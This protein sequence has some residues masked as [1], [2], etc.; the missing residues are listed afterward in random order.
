MIPDK[1]LSQGS[2]M[3]KFFR[4]H[5]VIAVKELLDVDLAPIQRMV[6]RDMW[7]R[8]N[9]IFVGG[10]GSGKTYL[11]A[12]GAVLRALLFPGYRIGL[13]SATF[14]Q[15]L[16]TNL[17]N[18][19]VFTNEGL[20]SSPTEFY[21]SI[22]ENTEIQSLESTNK[23]LDKWINDEKE[24][25]IIK[26]ERGFEIG[27]LYEHKV[28]VLDENMNLIYK[29]LGDLHT[30][31]YL[32]I[33]KGFGLFG[34]D[35]DL[36]SIKIDE[37]WL[38]ND[39]AR[40]ITCPTK[41]TPDL[42]YLF[43]IICGDGCIANKLTEVAFGND[44]P[45]LLDSFDIIIQKFF[46]ITTRRYKG[47]ISRAM[48]VEL[49]DFLIKCGI[50]NTTAIDKS[51]PL[52]VKRSSRE[53]VSSFLSG[54][55]DT[56]GSFG[57]SKVKSGY[58]VGR[59]DLFSVS[60]KMLKEVQAMLLNLDIMSSLYKSR[61][62]SEGYFGNRSKL[63]KF[64]DSY[65]LSIN[66]LANI[67]KFK[68]II[69]FRLTRKE[70]ELEQYLSNSKSKVICHNVL[71]FSLEI[72]CRLAASCKKLFPG[73]Y[74]SKNNS[75]ILREYRLSKCK[76]SQIGYTQDKISRLLELAK[77]ADVLTYEYHVLKRIINLN[78]EFV[79]VKK[80][81]PHKGK[82]VDV[83][84]ENE[85]CYWAGGFIN[86]N[87]KHIF[88]A[89][90][91]LYQQ[92]PIFQEAVAKPPTKASDSV[93]IRF[94]APPG[95]HGS[96]IEGI[97]LGTGEKIRGARYFCVEGSSLIYTDKGLISIRDI[98]DKGLD[99]KVYTLDGFEAP[100]LGVHLPES[101]VIR[102]EAEG[103][104]TLIGTPIHP[105][106]NNYFDFI[107]LKDLNVGDKVLAFS[108]GIVPNVGKSAYF[109]D[110]RIKDISYTRSD[111]YDFTIPYAHHFISNGF[112]SHNTLCVDE[113]NHIPEDI[114]DAVITPM[115][116]TSMNP[117][118]RVRYY[119]RLDRLKAGGFD[120]DDKYMPASNKLLHT[121]SGYFKFNYLWDRMKFYWS[122]LREGSNDH[123]VWQV[124]YNFLPPHFLDVKALEQA[125]KQM[126]KA[127]FDMEYRALMV[128]DSDGFYKGSLLAAATPFGAFRIELSGNHAEEYILC[129][130]PAAGT[131]VAAFAIMVIK[132]G[133]PN[134]I[135]FAKEMKKTSFPR[136]TKVM[137]ELIFSR[138]NII[139]IFMD[140]GGGG[141]SIRDLFEMG[142][143][144][145]PPVLEDVK[146]NI[147]KSG[148]KI[149]Q[150]VNFSPDWIANANYTAVSLLEHKQLIFPSA[151]LG[152]QK[153]DEED[154][155][156]ELIEKDLKYQILNIVVTETRMGRMHF[157][158]PSKGQK[159]DL[160]STFLL[161]CAGIEQLRRERAVPEL[162]TKLATG[163]VES[164]VDVEGSYYGSGS[165][166]LVG[167]PVPK[168]II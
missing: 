151:P 35:N 111:T 82:T 115:A 13:V 77:Q 8:N 86:H 120:I 26:T 49:C 37:K 141:H 103:G 34:N 74:S 54:L 96:W 60:L 98:I 85:H 168:R 55:Y 50:S 166:I 78:L 28:L 31:E 81:L 110:V 30:G 106:M 122:E 142:V 56:D 146:E 107:Q 11:Q 159:K 114:Y 133:D 84:V 157:D 45:E 144:G 153:N 91:R 125:K 118:E 162:G 18:I 112:V 12:L 40:H 80:I 164:N 7:F 128:S 27:G 163:I 47:P 123:A 129:A 51:I 99:I 134:K 149:L 41:L 130:D 156:Y 57:A 38:K 92:S 104:Y 36:S 158:T 72:T 95:G 116:I 127:L 24:G 165:N 32:A 59:I 87:S 108:L 61:S 113:F 62:A 152:A 63:S 119:E 148:R 21:D 9:V 70:D 100:T 33:K 97:P 137:Q 160:Y 6:F 145:F 79:K 93:Y 154:K 94:K 132:L 150:L 131:D 15:C 25:L 22:T 5:P 44:D 88:D 121:S 2:S 73:F 1:F 124:P 109:Q 65:V 136:M 102:I 43:G 10:R 117:M 19:C 67:K 105:V 29:E 58:N 135:V 20:K 76:P 46:N 138:F 68:E 14:R 17:D 139:R 126:S 48:S 101:D 53:C 89:C 69:G 75:Y 71:P 90:E 140:S 155:V 23:V 147:F 167:T 161:G 83:E 143:N 39:R 16:F 4:E 64:L 52:V 42:A 3:I 66:G